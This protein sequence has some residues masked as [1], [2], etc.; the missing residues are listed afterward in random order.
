M[1]AE[2][3]GEEERN[4]DEE[5]RDGEMERYDDKECLDE[6]MVNVDMVA[7]H[8]VEIGIEDGDVSLQIH[9]NFQSG[10]GHGL[11]HLVFLYVLPGSRAT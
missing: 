6:E 10:E 8:T 4:D 9:E 7:D 5:W 2:R 3:S 1:V 11:E